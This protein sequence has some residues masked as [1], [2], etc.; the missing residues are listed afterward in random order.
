MAIPRGVQGAPYMRDCLC[1]RH[2]RV[3]RIGRVPESWRLGIETPEAPD[4]PAGD[5]S[6]ML[7]SSAVVALLCEH[8]AQR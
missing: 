7:D 5:T 3:I 4:T 8:A 1:D 6:I 2:H